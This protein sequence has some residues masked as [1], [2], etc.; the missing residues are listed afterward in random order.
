M[1]YQPDQGH[2]LPRD[3][4]TSLVA[5]RPIAW[6]STVNPAGLVNLAPFSFY[7]I[8]STRPPAVMFSCS[9]PKHTGQNAR[10]SGEFVVNVPSFDMRDA[11]MATS[12]DVEADVSEA[13]LAG[14]EMAPSVAVRP[15]R[16]K[17]SR[18]ALECRYLQSVELDFNTVVFG[19]V[20][21]VFIDDALLVDGHVRW[22]EGKLLYR[23]GYL[24]YGTVGRSFA[25]GRPK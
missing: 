5:P 3:P 6:I 23:L 22:P 12:E 14:V 15:P 21:G 24:N 19:R 25:M 18:V 10:A 4:M 9:G 1:Y 13:E 7:N 16:V 8:V 17:D 11:M 2:G 20:V